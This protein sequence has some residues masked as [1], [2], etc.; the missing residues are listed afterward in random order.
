MAS[1]LDQVQNV[2]NGMQ[3][4][5]QGMSYEKFSEEYD[6]DDFDDLEVEHRELGG[7]P[8]TRHSCSC[9]QCTNHDDDCDGRCLL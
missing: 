6:Q 9:V 2:D 3:S 4:L 5:L 1:F 7:V 8:I